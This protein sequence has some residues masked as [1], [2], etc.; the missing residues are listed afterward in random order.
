MANV[1]VLPDDYDGLKKEYLVLRKEL[2]G[3]KQEL[4]ANK[5][6]LKV[7]EAVQLE[8]QSEIEILQ[9]EE[10]CHRLKQ[11]EKITQLEENISNVKSKCN[12]Q[13]QALEAEL[14]AKEEENEKLKA[15]MEILK[16]S[17]LS[18]TPSDDTYKLLEELTNLKHE[19]EAL[20]EHQEELKLSIE[21]LQKNC[22]A[23]EE[24]LTVSKIILNSFF[25]TKHNF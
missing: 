10:N 13:I 24:A 3:V 7:F 6:Q 14:T 23:L 9:S 17:D 21:I 19:Y 11:Q 15:E 8:Y 12:K 5:R 18:Q 2:D 4:Y 1:T 25:V 22:F 20:L 16:K